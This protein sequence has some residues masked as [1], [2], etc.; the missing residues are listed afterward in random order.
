MSTEGLLGVLPAVSDVCLTSRPT[1][2]GMCF[3]GTL[4]WSCLL[5]GL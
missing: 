2:V 4:Y 1:C 5:E 3:F